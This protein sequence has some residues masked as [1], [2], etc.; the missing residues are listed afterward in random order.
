MLVQV[1]NSDKYI[2]E[3]IFWLIA[4]TYL[5]ILTKTFIK[6]QKFKNSAQDFSGFLTPSNSSSRTCR[7]TAHIF[8]FHDS[9]TKSLNIITDKWLL[10][11]V[12]ISVKYLFRSDF[13]WTSQFFYCTPE[14]SQKREWFSKWEFRSPLIVR[15]DKLSAFFMSWNL[16]AVVTCAWTSD[17]LLE[18]SI[19]GGLFNSRETRNWSDKASRTL[20]HESRIELRMSFLSYHFIITC[21]KLL[22]ITTPTS[23]TE[24]ENLKP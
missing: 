3:L 4:G 2:K 7:I 22:K 14:N 8:R 11:F 18:V 16:L 19:L 24:S 9:L 12:N 23:K 1:V 6:N 21:N 10:K 15:P 13:D 20:K 17:C 5:N